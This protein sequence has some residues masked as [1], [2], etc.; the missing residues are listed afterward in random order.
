MNNSIN[1]ENENTFFSPT[2]LKKPLNFNY[3]KSV[4]RKHNK[5]LYNSE[6]KEDCFFHSD[7][8]GTEIKIFCD[9]ENRK[10]NTLNN[11]KNNNRIS[12]F[13]YNPKYFKDENKTSFFNT[14]LNNPKT[15][16]KMKSL[17]IDSQ[18]KNNFLFKNDFNNLNYDNYKIT[19]VKRKTTLGNY[20]NLNNKNFPQNFM[21]KRIRNL[22][23]VVN[24]LYSNHFLEKK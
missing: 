4:P 17:F 7:K 18:N 23:Q 21:E 1:Q 24:H 2:N 5:S 19:H 10:E 15:H 13:K 11:N 16:V 14:N 8:K 22:S 20:L 9:K 3:M 6:R 12:L